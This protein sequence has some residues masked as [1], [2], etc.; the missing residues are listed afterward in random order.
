MQ[1]AA[2]AVRMQWCGPCTYSFSI[3]WGYVRILIN[4][5]RWHLEG[6]SGEHKTTGSQWTLLRRGEAGSYLTGQYAA[7]RDEVG[8]LVGVSRDDGPARVVLRLCAAGRAARLEEHQVGLGRLG[9]EANLIAI[10]LVVVVGTKACRLLHGHL[11]WVAGY[12]RALDQHDIR[13]AELL[14]TGSRLA[15]TARTAATTAQAAV[16]GQTRVDVELLLLL[17]ADGQHYHSKQKDERDGPQG[18]DEDQS[19]VQRGV[20]AAGSA[21]AAG[22]MLSARASC[23]PRD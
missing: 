16:A 15:A 12:I 13:F 10:V 3:N 1:Q 5:N 8:L 9:C 21:R 6:N 20:G 14:L 17:A 18:D 7:I 22:P 19:Q 23:A 2:Q 11:N 4:R